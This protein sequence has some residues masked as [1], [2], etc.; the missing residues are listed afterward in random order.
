MSIIFGATTL[1]AVLASVLIY[2]LDTFKRQ[3]QVTGSLG[4]NSEYSRGSLI[5][6]LLKFNQLGYTAMYRGFSLHFLRTL[7][8]PLIHY[9]M[10]SNLKY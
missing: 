4:F 1:N 6:N 5:N 2:P 3:L 8:F 9:M 10:Y 7:H